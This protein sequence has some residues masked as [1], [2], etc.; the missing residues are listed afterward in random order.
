METRIQYSDIDIKIE[1]I[2]EEDTEELSSFSCGNG[3]LDDFFHNE[4]H[5]CSKYHYVSAYCAR[6]AQS[7]EIVAVFTL[8][9][10]A[11]VIGDS[12][13]DLEDFIETSAIRINEEYQPVFKQQTSYPAINIG[14]LGIRAD[15]QSKGI[16]T[17]V[18]DFVLATFISYEIA[19]CQFITVDSLNNERT[20]KFYMK[21]GFSNQ[22][23]NDMTHE[24]RRMYLPI[25]LY[26]QEEDEE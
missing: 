9:N 16:G 15:L 7:G 14:H 4:I 20:N 17:K 25:E 23:N 12:G 19:G 18:L 24:T 13:D 21:N 22:T 11:V 1:K 10:D 26:R 3:A 8:A 5:I 2:K 6:D